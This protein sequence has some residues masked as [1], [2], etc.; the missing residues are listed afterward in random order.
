M[1]F[2]KANAVVLFVLQASIFHKSAKISAFWQRS[3]YYLLAYHTKTKTELK[4]CLFYG[5]RVYVPF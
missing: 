3:Y 2:G 5:V 4:P 1:I